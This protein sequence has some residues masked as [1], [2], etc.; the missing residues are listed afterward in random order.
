MQWCDGPF[1]GL[2]QE[3]VV[4]GYTG[5]ELEFAIGDVYPIDA[6][7]VVFSLLPCENKDLNC[8]LN[9]TSE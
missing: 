3:E 2:A 7:R 5:K 4:I 9:E 8:L 6:N 1:G